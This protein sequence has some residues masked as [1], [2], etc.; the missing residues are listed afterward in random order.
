MIPTALPKYPWQKIASDIFMLHGHTY[1]IIVDYFSRFPEVIQLPRTTSQTLI[2]SFKLVFAH[3]GIPEE[4][5]TDNG[6]QYTSKE[7]KAFAA[8]YGF[9]HTTS[10]PYYPRGTRKACL[11]PSVLAT[12]GAHAHAQGANMSPPAPLDMIS[13]PANSTRWSKGPGDSSEPRIMN[14]SPQREYQSGDVSG[15]SV[16]SGREDLSYP[17]SQKFTASITPDDLSDFTALYREHCKA[18]LDVVQNLQ[19]QMV[20]NLWHHFWLCKN[21]EGWLTSSIHGYPTKSINSRVRVFGNV[22]SIGV[23]TQRALWLGFHG[24]SIFKTLRCYMSL[25]HLAQAARAVLQNPSQIS[26]MLADLNGVD[27]ANV[28]EQASWV[29][30]VIRELTLRS[31]ANF[32]SFHLIRLLYDEY[33]FFLIEHKVTDAMGKITIDIIESMQHSRAILRADSFDNGQK[34]FYQLPRGLDFALEETVIKRTQVA[35]TRHIRDLAKRRAAATDTHHAGPCKTKSDHL[36][37]HTIS[38]AQDADVPGKTSKGPDSIVAFSLL[39]LETSGACGKTNGFGKMEAMICNGKGKRTNLFHKPDQSSVAVMEISDLLAKLQSQLEHSEALRLNAE[40]QLATID[41]NAHSSIGVCIRN[42]NEG[43]SSGLLRMI[44]GKITED[45]RDPFNVQVVV[46]EGEDGGILLQLQDAEGVF[47]EADPPMEEEETEDAPQQEAAEQRENAEQEEDEESL[48]AKLD[49]VVKERDELKEALKTCKERL[50]AVWKANCAQLREF[51]E[52]LKHAEDEARTLQKGAREKQQEARST[53]P[54]GSD[55]SE[56][57]TSKSTGKRVGKAPPI[58]SFS[59]DCYEVQL[60][61]WLPSLERAAEWNRWSP[62]EKLMQ[63][64]GHLRGKALQEWTLI[65]E[66]E[67]TTYVQA[68]AALRTRLDTGSK[69]LAAQD[70]RHLCQDEKESVSE[71]IRKLERTFRVAYG[72]DNMSQETRDTLLLGQMQE[73]LKHEVMKAPAVSGATSY[74]ELCVAAKNEERRLKELQKREHYG[75]IGHPTP[76]EPTRS[77]VVKPAEKTN[78]TMRCFKCHKDGHIARDCPG[79]EPESRSSGRSLH[80][81]DGVRKIKVTDSG[82]KTH[83]VRLEVQKVP[84]YGIIDSGSDITIIG[85]S[86]FK[87]VA[88][89]ARLKK[90][91]LMTADKTPRTYDQKTFSLDGRIDLELSFE[92][93]SMKTPVYLKNDAHDQLLLSEG[94]CRQLG[95]ITYHHLAEPWRGSKKADTCKSK[96]H[97][98]TDA[99]VPRVVVNLVQSL[100]LPSYKSVVVPVQVSECTSLGAVLF[101]ENSSIRELCGVIIVDSLIRPDGKGIAHV[102]A[103]NRTGY[104]ACLERDAKSHRWKRFSSS[105]HPEVSYRLDTRKARL[106]DMLDIERSDIMP[107]QKAE[108]VDMLLGFHNAF[109]LSEEERGETDLIQMTIDTGTTQP[110]KSPLRRMP[111]AVKAESSCSSKKEKDGAHRFCVD[112]RGLNEVTKAD[113]FPLPRVDDLLDQLG[114]SRYFTTLDLAAGFWQIRMHPDSKEKTAFA[115]PQG[116]F[117]FQVMP[118]GLMN[119]PAVFQRLMQQVLA[120]LNPAEGPEFVSVY[121]DDILI[122]SANLEDHIGHLKLVLER[123]T[124]ANLNLKPSKCHFIR[125]EVEYLG[126]VITPEDCELTRIREKQHECRC[127]VSESCWTSH[128]ASRRSASSGIQTD[129]TVAELLAAEPQQVQQV[130]FREEQKKDP[131]VMQTIRFLEEGELPQEEKQARKL[132]LQAPMF[133]V[134]DGILYYVETKGGVRRVVLPKHLQRQLVEESHGGRYA[135]HFC[136]PKVYSMLAKHWWWEGM[137]TDVLQFCRSCPECAIATGG[138]RPV[139]LLLSPIPVQRPFQ[140]FGVDLMELPATSQG[141]KYV[142]VFQDFFSKWPLVFPVPDQKSERIVKLLAD[143]IIPFCGVPEALLSD[144]GTNLLSHLM[145]DVCRA[146]G[147][148]KLNTTAYHPQCDGMVE[149]FNRTLKTALRK[150]AAKFGNQWDR[151]LSGVLWAYRNTPHDSTGEKPSY[152]LFGIDCRAPLESSLLPVENLT[153]SSVSD[154]REELLLSLSSAR[155]LACDAIQKAQCRY[156]KGYDK[157]ARPTTHKIGDW[158]L[159]KFPHEESGKNRKLS[160]P[161]HGPYRLLSCTDTDVV[162]AKVYFP[163]EGHIQVHQNR[164]TICPRDFPNGYYWYG[165]SQSSNK[166]CPQWLDA[167]LGSV[168]RPDEGTTDSQQANKELQDQA[169]TEAAAPSPTTEDTST[170]VS[171]ENRPPRERTGRYSLREK[172]RPPRR[173]LN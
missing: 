71:Y 127:P 4:L 99:K 1:L 23:W 29:F 169:S 167:V 142:V 95:I 154:Y 102:V 36:V 7:M 48:K 94:V 134:T 47:L 128:S 62:E 105:K 156:K 35:I 166:P 153:P 130:D 85:S 122:F 98:V 12:N 32:G 63:L 160:H 148:Q 146:L 143:E 151:Y 101:E 170:D 77:N 33:M 50:N 43:V 136:G 55:V 152:L 82:S 17:P 30:P 74:K 37:D 116:L 138:G 69:T 171:V 131:H 129:G 84:V 162:A 108:L 110:R 168:G 86:L 51:E 173:Y 14:Y 123:I 20:E 26:Q 46:K 39:C 25:N 72:R 106:K 80:K 124:Q 67:R 89:V 112:Y 18:I 115:T 31:A 65:S 56:A 107:A 2:E 59:G 60:D 141:N 172:I 75:K 49:E 52:A 28:Q 8:S 76:R 139:K 149:R 118:F 53:S 161:W 155:K 70:F 96:D 165:K 54:S 126:H 41:D 27:F 61:D 150:H 3:N 88:V 9:Q 90:G 21:L 81:Q 64:A 132:A 16:P 135:G 73:G 93:K 120:G 164:T 92:G 42:T 24:R 91:S 100:H 19:F 140:I 121:I 78:S 114:H 109:S 10:S 103:E 119:S 13:K 145:L 111:L 5:V 125:K 133:A 83:C 45:G 44:E 40:Y 144:R 79:P 22:V 15:E 147:I 58:D 87:R 34:T 97:A 113:G 157:H 57:S 68:V 163:D 38:F 6:P 66:T 104:T 159:I 158:I 117:E 137:Y 11:R